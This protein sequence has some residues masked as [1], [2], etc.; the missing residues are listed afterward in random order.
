MEM[1]EGVLTL[2]N[3]LFILI[4]LLSTIAFADLTSEK[5]KQLFQEANQ[6][7]KD[8]KLESKVLKVGDTFPD[9]KF[10]GKNVSEFLKEGPL[11]VTFYRGGWCPY[12]IKQLKDINNSLQEIKGS[13]ANLIALSPEKTSEVEKTKRKN[14]LN[15]TLISD[16][17]NTIARQLNLTFKVEPSVVKEYKALGID[18]AASQGNDSYELPMPATFVI[19]KDRKIA[20]VFADAD[21]TKRASTEE[22]IQTVKKLSM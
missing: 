9:L 3:F 14:A 10:K 1:K 2:K 21:Y 20:Y 13:G 15:F 6:R 17:G 4:Y 22:I 8:T 19:G 12:C 5:R 11:V 16:E 7:L 18:L